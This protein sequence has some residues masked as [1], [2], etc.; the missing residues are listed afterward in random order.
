MNQTSKNP[1]LNNVHNIWHTLVVRAFPCRSIVYILDLDAGG[2]HQ[3]PS[4]VRHRKD[5]LGVGHHLFAFHR[6]S[7]L[8]AR[9][10]KQMKLA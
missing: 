7:D 8:Y 3:K 10:T 1:R 6:R 5:R 9:G 2:L 4:V